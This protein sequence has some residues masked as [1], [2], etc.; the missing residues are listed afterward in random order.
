MISVWI[1]E[2]GLHC[3]LKIGIYEE[4]GISE[5][6]AWGIMLADIARHISLALESIY[7]RNVEKSIREITDAL[8]EEIQVP[9]SG[10]TG[11]IK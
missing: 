5:V 6:R 4:R 8:Y 10:I 3:S 1:A 7:G 9:S 2:N 11:N